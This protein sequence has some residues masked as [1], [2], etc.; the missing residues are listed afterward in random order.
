MILLQQDGGTLETQL[1]MKCCGSV[2]PLLWN[3]VGNRYESTEVQLVSKKEYSLE[4]KQ[5]FNDGRESH[6]NTFDLVIE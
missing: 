6:K 2:T 5:V 3:R 4:V 1:R